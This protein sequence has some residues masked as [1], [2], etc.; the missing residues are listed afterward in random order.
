[1]QRFELEKLFPFCCLFESQQFS[2]SEAGRSFRIGISKC[3]NTQPPLK[4]APHYKSLYMALFSCVNDAIAIC[5]G[6][7]GY[8][9]ENKKAANGR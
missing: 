9:K 4:F 7:Q 8:P 1:M 3:P 2:P 6:G 5:G